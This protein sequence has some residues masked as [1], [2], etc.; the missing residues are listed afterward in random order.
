[1]LVLSP[2]EGSLQEVMES[3]ALHMALTCL[4]QLDSYEQMQ[5]NE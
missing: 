2:H 4:D 1:M 5:L 3:W